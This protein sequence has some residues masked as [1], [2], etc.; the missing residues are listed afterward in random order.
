[1]KILI[2]IIC[3]YALNRNKTAEL[4]LPST[5]QTS[6]VE[7]RVKLKIDIHLTKSPKC[8]HIYKLCLYTLEE[9]NIII[10]IL[11]LLLLCLLLTS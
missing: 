9:H 6:D 7:F 10:K 8:D 4:Y 3:V 5:F 2:L 11:L 1:M